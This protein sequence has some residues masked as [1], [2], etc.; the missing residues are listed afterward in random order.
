MKGLVGFLVVVISLFTIQCSNEIPVTSE[1]INLELGKIVLNIDKVNAP[2][3]VVVVEAFLTR[4]NHDTLYGSLNLLNPTTA[5]ILFDNVQAGEWHLTVD[6]KDSSGTVLYTG[7]TNINVQ[8]G[9]LTQVNLTLIPTGLGTG[10]IYIYV[11]WGNTNSQW[12]DYIGNPVL[13]KQDIYFDNYGVSES[14]IIYDNNIY[15]MWYAGDAGS[16][17]HYILYAESQDGINWIHPHSGPVLS[18]GTNNSWDS[19]SV[20]PGAVI[21][22]ND[23]YKMY[24]SGWAYIDNPWHVGLATSSDGINW[25]KNPSPVLFGG[26][27]GDYQ[28]KATSVVKNEDIYY[29]YYLEGF[30]AQSWNIN[31]ATSSDGLNWTRYSSNPILSTTNTWEGIGIYS[32]SIIKENG[33]YQMVYQ[34]MNNSAFGFATSQD[35]IHWTTSQSNPFFTKENTSNHWGGGAIAY[36]NF[37]RASNSELRIYYTGISLNSN[38]QKIGF[39]K[40]L[41]N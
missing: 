41:I 19:H 28:V 27:N 6:A 8:A 33:T 16:G 38:I 1:P 30:H 31:L 18:P 21:K 5:D 13:T 3:N 4:E 29:M 11:T 34:G 37:V 39:M 22:E 32:P 36:P 7:E 26:T 9:I 17:V 15:K 14:S 10:S 23:V 35:G 25:E 40:K 20:V 24:Y 12:V 2:A